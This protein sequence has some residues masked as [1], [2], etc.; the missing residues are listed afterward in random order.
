[1]N[2]RLITTMERE[3]K[4]VLDVARIESRTGKSFRITLPKKVVNQL[5]LTREDSVLVFFMEGERIIIEKLR[6]V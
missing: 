4:T 6:Q 3:Q 2:L 5:K 1:M